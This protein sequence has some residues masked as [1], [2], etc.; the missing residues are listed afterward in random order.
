VLYRAKVRVAVQY[1][2][3][4]LRERVAQQVIHRRVRQRPLKRKLAPLRP[5]CCN[6][7]V[8]EISHELNSTVRSRQRV[9]AGRP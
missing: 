2:F 6:R 8:Q 5:T 4:S 7:V 1:S 9:S 3:A